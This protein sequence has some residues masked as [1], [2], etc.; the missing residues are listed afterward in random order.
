MISEES[1]ETTTTTQKLCSDKIRPLVGTTKN[2]FKKIIIYLF[3]F[4]QQ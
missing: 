4:F 1:G 3:H 2:P